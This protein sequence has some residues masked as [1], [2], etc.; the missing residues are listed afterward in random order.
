MLV[1]SSWDRQTYFEFPSVLRRIVKPGLQC[2]L[3][4]VKRTWASALQMSAYDPKATLAVHCGNRLMRPCSLWVG[5]Q[6]FRC[7]LY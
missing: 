2:L 6:L 3:S 5:I 7:L 4:G 1:G